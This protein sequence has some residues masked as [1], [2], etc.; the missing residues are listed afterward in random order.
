MRQT[1]SKKKFSSKS[2][3]DAKP[4]VGLT[5][6]LKKILKIGVGVLHQKTA[7]GD[8][9][10]ILEKDTSHVFRLNHVAAELW[11]LIDGKRSLGAIVKRLGKK[12][13]V[14]SEILEQKSH[15]LI[16]KLERAGLVR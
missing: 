1:Q 8:V 12:H 4:S 6:D 3:K 11:T 10:L 15:Q 13:R 14:S 9:T 7:K 16:L 5:L 2:N